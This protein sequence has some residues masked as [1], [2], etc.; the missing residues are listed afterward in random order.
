[1]AGAFGRQ[2]LTRC[3]E[4]HY[5]RVTATDPHPTGRARRRLWW[6]GRFGILR[7]AQ[8]I[9]K[10]ILEI[11]KMDCLAE[12]ACNRLFSG[13]DRYPREAPAQADKYPG[14]VASSATAVKDPAGHRGKQ[15]E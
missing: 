12:L 14:V 2:I 7:T 8:K 15:A 11:G 3:P 6:P 5:G 10:P 1:M 4:S 9:R 13:V